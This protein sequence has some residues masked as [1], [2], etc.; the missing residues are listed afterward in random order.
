MGYVMG[1]IAVLVGLT[2]IAI[3]GFLDVNKKP[4]AGWEVSSVNIETIYRFHG[5]DLKG[6]YISHQ[7][8]RFWARKYNSNTRK[9]D[10]NESFETFTAAEN[11]IYKHAGTSRITE[12]TTR[13]K[14]G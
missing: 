10:L 6:Y 3:Q 12:P 2:F 14:G 13:G 11:A 4:R 1:A 9:W 8:P 7:H 5:A